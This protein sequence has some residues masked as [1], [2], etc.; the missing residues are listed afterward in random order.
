MRLP[1]LKRRAT[2]SAPAFVQRAEDAA[3]APRQSRRSVR[4]PLRVRREA[5]RYERP[6]KPEVTVGSDRLTVVASAA[7]TPGWRRAAIV[8]GVPWLTAV[9]VGSL[10]YL[11]W[12]A[13]DGFGVRLMIWVVLMVL[14]AALHVIA[15]LTL[16]G[17]AYSR[18]GIETLMIDPARITLRRQ[19]GRFPIE[20][21]IARGIVEGATPVPPPADGRP[22]SRIE[23]RSWR[24]AL[25]FGAGMTEAEAGEVLYV[26][27]AFFEREEYARHALT[28]T[29]PEAT[30]APT[31]EDGAAEAYCGDDGDE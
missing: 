26:M 24:S 20:M 18:E 21:H 19:A 12:G 14:T 3:H 4:P 7:E 17:T 25:R 16:W 13:P 23:V 30:I 28:P 22:H 6:D 11:G 27:N 8:Y 2:A 1:V 10:W 15:V 29:T 31:R 5:A 9:G